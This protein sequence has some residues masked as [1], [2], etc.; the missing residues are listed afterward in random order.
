[1]NTHKCPGV[2]TTELEPLQDTW[3]PGLQLFV[4]SALSRVSLIDSQSSRT[5]IGYK[6][7]SDTFQCQTILQMCVLLQG[8]EGIAGVSSI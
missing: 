6:D 5:D 3:C 8:N 1:M 4:I 7:F 2:R